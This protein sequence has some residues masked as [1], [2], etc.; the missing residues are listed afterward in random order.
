MSY[1]LSKTEIKNRII[2]KKYMV[3]KEELQNRLNRTK[4]IF[5]KIIIDIK[6]VKTENLKNSSNILWQLGHIQ[7]FYLNLIF[8][9]LL[10]T[11]LR[12]SLIQKFNWSYKIFQELIKFYD[13]FITPSYLRNQPD[14]ILPLDIILELSK[15]IFNKLES[16]LSGNESNFLNSYLIMLGLLH[17]EM[18]HEALIFQ[19]LLNNYIISW[20]P[21]F[22]NIL[23][24]Q[25]KSSNLISSIEWIS[26]NT[27]TFIQGTDDYSTHL[28]FDNEQPPFLKSI[29]KFQ[30]S[31]YPITEA[32]FT[33]FILAGGYKNK[34][35]WNSVSWH[36]KEKENIN[37]PLYWQEYLDKNSKLKQFKIKKNGILHS[38]LSNY[39]VC[40]VSFWE[41]QAYCA[42]KKVRLPTESEYE[43][44]ATNGGKDRFPWGQ[45]LD[46]GNYCNLNYQRYIVEVT[47]Y[48]NGNN[49]KGVSQLIGNVWQ[50][51][52][53]PIYPYENFVIDPV[54]REMSYPFFGEKRI[55]KGG[56][57]AVS[58]FLIHPKYRNAQLPTCREQFIGF[59]ICL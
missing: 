18:H 45:D 31:K 3:N 24:I 28:I 16:I 38:S 27:N 6:K 47:E 58:D 35:F 55:C 5:E 1:I 34:D 57:W 56:C 51:C 40:H 48:K 2:S 43:Y 39:P 7:F 4:K 20:I 13:S 26:Y 36:W 25:P 50:W 30:V 29:A 11:L 22:N 49:E 33:Q 37:L 9:N 17:Q 46:S 21:T 44:L 53:E 12:K 54:Y 59:R 23:S 32:Q 15:W 19:L 14:I 42:W 10:D 8:P 52:Q 41:A